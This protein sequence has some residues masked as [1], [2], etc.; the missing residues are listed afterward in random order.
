[1]H[2]SEMLCVI[3]LCTLSPNEAALLAVA[4][5][6]HCT[7][8]QAVVRGPGTMLMTPACLRE[9]PALYSAKASVSSSRRMSSV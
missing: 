3:S 1:M 2:M 5:P 6:R 4:A 8:P 7:Y 9:A